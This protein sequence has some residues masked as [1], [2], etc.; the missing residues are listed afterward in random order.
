MPHA[1]SRPTDLGIAYDTCGYPRNGP[2]RIQ[3]V[4]NL[5]PY[6]MVTASL[7]HPASEGTSIR[8]YPA[9]RYEP[10]SLARIDILFRL[11]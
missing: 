11:V 9:S 5:L 8:M 7:A 3:Y 4:V 1:E 10:D 2:R 6:N